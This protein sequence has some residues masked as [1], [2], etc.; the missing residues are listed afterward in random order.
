VIDP[1]A[2]EQA[3]DRFGDQHSTLRQPRDRHLEGGIGFERVSVVAIGSPGR[4]TMPDSG[5]SPLA[6]ADVMT[7]ILVRFEWH[8]DCPVSGPRPPPVPCTPRRQPAI[9][10]HGPI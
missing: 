4:S 9:V 2:K 5:S 3:V 1:V 6:R 8:D 10:Q 7:A